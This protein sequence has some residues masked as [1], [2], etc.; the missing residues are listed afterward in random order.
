MKQV[1]VDLDG[2]LADFDGHY[3][4]L[5]GVRPDQDT[6]NPPELWDRIREHGNFYRTEP[7]M[8]DLDELWPGICKLHPYP[9]VL[10][11]IPAS[12]PR[13]REQK[14]G[15]VREYLGPTVPIITCPSR[16]KYKFGK[17]GDI[18]IDDR[19]KY[20]HPWIEMGGLFIHHKST[21][22]TLAQLA[23]LLAV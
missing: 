14:I 16:D 13:V 1:F 11:G 20:K 12:I 22:G 4:K 8:P 10:T 19:T 9:V 23:A 7:P 17:P 18:L 15:W 3:E 6:Y 2:V 21:I 5:F